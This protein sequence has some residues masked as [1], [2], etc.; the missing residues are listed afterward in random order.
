MKKQFII[1]VTITILLFVNFSGCNE[2][3][4]ETEDA[5]QNSENGDN[6]ETTN[7]DELLQTVCQTANDDYPEWSKLSS[8]III[9]ENLDKSFNFR[10][11]PED[12]SIGIS[13]PISSS[14]TLVDMDFIGLN[15]ISYV[16]TQDDKWH[17]C[18]FKLNGMDAPD[19]SIIYNRTDSVSSIDISPINK[20]E[21]ITFY[22]KGN[23]VFLEYLDISDS[24]EEN[25]LGTSLADSNNKK[26]A[27]SAKGNY[28]YLL[29]DDTL[30][31]FDIA[32][33]T[34]LDEINSIESVVWVGD[35]YLI[36]SISDKTYIYDTD[37][38]EKSEVSK[39]GSVR[40]LCFN[41]KNNGVIAYTEQS[42]AKTVNCE[43]WQTLG[44]TQNAKIITLANEQTAIMEKENFLGYWRF[45][46]ADWI[47][48]LSEGFSNFATVWKRY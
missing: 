6:Q 18:L 17:I 30:R 31:I 4:S 2:Q 15:E 25:L 47:V 40:D 44:S 23:N 9:W 38:K 22:T 28:V 41:P 29:Y 3:T 34:K 26:L 27:V 36:Y 14:E 5:P 7:G 16:K 19:N 46:N 42:I 20:N 35:S 33:K 43:T 10:N 1:L 8:D 32:S 48:S 11:S 24:K 13:S 45:D 12:M 21:F 37:S 39:M